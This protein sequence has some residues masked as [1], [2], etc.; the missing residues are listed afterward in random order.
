[1]KK[2]I[3]ALIAIGIGAIGCKNE[4]CYICTTTHIL[5]TT[6]TIEGYPKTITGNVIELCD[7]EEAIKN[8]EE[9]N[10]GMYCEV[11]NGITIIAGYS[12]NCEEE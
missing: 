6:Q 11:E 3:I 2:L 12:T 9:S 5:A 7:T 10:E 1:M 4:I 8:Y